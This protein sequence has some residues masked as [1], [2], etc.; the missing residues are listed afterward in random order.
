MPRIANRDVPHHV[1]TEFAN[2]NNTLVGQCSPGYV[3]AGRLPTQWRD[4]IR[5]QEATYVVY[6]YAT[7][8]AFELSDGRRFIPDVRYSP[9]TS[10]HQALVRR[11]W[12]NFATEAPA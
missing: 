6:S 3:N 10:R 4:L 2:H 7:P 8:I 9:T 5:G 11:G 12:A 1:G